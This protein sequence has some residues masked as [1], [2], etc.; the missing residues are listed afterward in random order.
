[1]KASKKAR[2]KLDARLK[3]YE[4]ITNVGDK[5][6]VSPAGF[7]MTRPGSLKKSK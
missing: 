3:A 6:K 5:G 7:H 4:E 1:M 2:K